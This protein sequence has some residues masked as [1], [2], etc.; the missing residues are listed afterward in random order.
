MKDLDLFLQRRHRPSK[1]S[2][3]QHEPE[4]QPHTPDQRKTRRYG[5]LPRD[6]LECPKT[7]WLTRGLRPRNCRSTHKLCI[8]R[9]ARTEA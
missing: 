4:V 9:V 6:S 1:L 2:Q 8:K 3:Q 5:M 7:K